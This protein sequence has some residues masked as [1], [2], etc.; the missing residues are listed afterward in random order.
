MGVL[1]R[2]LGTLALASAE[3]LINFVHTGDLHSTLLEDTATVQ[4]GGEDESIQYGGFARVAG[5]INEL[6][7][8]NPCTLVVDS[9]DMFFGSVY[10]TKYKADSLKDI[11]PHMNYDVMTFGNHEFDLGYDDL[12]EYLKYVKKNF[13][14]TNLDFTKSTMNDYVKPYSIITLDECPSYNQDGIEEMTTSIKIGVVGALLN[15]DV[16]TV[17]FDNN[18][19]KLD[20]VKE[21]AKVS[22]MLKE[23]EKVDLVIFLSHMGIDKDLDNIKHLP[24][25]D[26]IF[27]GHTHT[28]LTER[29]TYKNLEH[30]TKDPYYDSL[31]VTSKGP[32]PLAISKNLTQ[33]DGD[34]AYTLLSHTGAYGEHIGFVSVYYNTETQKIN[35]DRT[36]K[37]SLTNVYPE[38]API[39]YDHNE[40]TVEYSHPL[41]VEGYLPTD[42][43]VE[44][45]INRLQQDLDTFLDNKVAKTENDLIGGKKECSKGET[46]MGDLVADTYRFSVPQAQLAFTNSGG[47]RGGIDKS[48]I[49]E[50]EI[51]EGI[52]FNNQ[53][54]SFEIEGKYIRNVFEVALGDE[55]T[56]SDGPRTTFL[57]I[58]GL[59]VRYNMSAPDGK[60]VEEIKVCKEQTPADLSALTV[61]ET[62]VCD[63]N[64]PDM[65]EDLKDENVYKAVTN[66]YMLGGHDHQEELR[67]NMKNAVVMGQEITLMET[68]LST[69]QS[70]R[71]PEY[72]DGRLVAD[73]L[74]GSGINSGLVVTVVV[75]VL[76]AAIVAGVLSFVLLRRRKVGGEQEKLLK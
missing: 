3:V 32:Y 9:G 68:Y 29:V 64:N 45:E 4:I 30:N 74:S 63:P 66:D 57:Q 42:D 49:T 47:I 35:A 75:V 2:L 70:V 73:P 54:V 28:T 13:V 59:F 62:E 15:S 20:E 50:R 1:L 19:E 61:E 10:F 7:R 46:G 23:T 41:F 51:Y 16:R 33:A 17:M 38:N 14:S 76:V 21:L 67:N 31:L 72:G 37:E 5:T 36:L 60:R 8:D 65:W 11:V 71:L 43:D 26:I 56:P 22:K 24:D 18:V 27:G 39:L 25:V 69:I 53:V 6:K 40:A 12:L 55:N 48:D 44:K 58:S 52:P 34:E